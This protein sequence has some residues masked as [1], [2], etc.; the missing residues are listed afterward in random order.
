MELLSLIVLQILGL[1]V[2][3]MGAAYGMLRRRLYTFLFVGLLAYQG[4]MAMGLL[5]LTSEFGAAVVFASQCVILLGASIL[6]AAVVS[7]ERISGWANESTPMN[8]VTA[9][10]EMWPAY[11]VT[12]LACACITLAIA[13]RRGP[14]LLSLNWESVR[15]EA[16]FLDSIATLLQFFVFPA[17][18]IAYRAG[19]RLWVLVFAAIAL[20]IFALMGSRAAL[21]A[22]LAVVAID[23]LR[24]SL[25][26]QT[27][28][29]IACVMAAIGFLIHIAGRVVRGLGLGGVYRVL[30]GEM[31]A[32]SLM[33][34][35]AETVEW[36]GGESEIARYFAFAVERDSFSDVAPFVSVTRW[37][38][39]YI[40]RALAPNIKP[41][42]ATYALWRHAANDGVFDSY[43]AVD[44]MLLLLKKGDTGSIHPMLWGELWVNGGWLAI[45]IA[46]VLL[47]A[48]AVL[49]DRVLYRAPKLAAVLVMPATVVGWLMVARGN[50]VIGLGYTYY[51]LPVALA[52][53]AGLGMLWWLA[54]ASH[55]L[56]GR[57]TPVDH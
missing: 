48:Q 28:F 25:T 38:T 20:A 10:I 46:A 6:L 50:S 1:A 57:R 9:A 18:W 56:V 13:A 45:P 30:T 24:S 26:R 41:E 12:V 39:M 40:P 29:R 23:V 49:F 8:P 5:G 55:S 31:D 2:V 44:Q 14:E 51:L 3:A 21:L 47:A 22:G 16:T 27:K 35:I 7:I 34:E 15:G 43:A 53:C 52:A 32:Q 11:C 4:V 33:R 37:L 19:K 54:H 42:D 36:T 17:V